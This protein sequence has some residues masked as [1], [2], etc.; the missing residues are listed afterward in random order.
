M[1]KYLPYGIIYLLLLPAL[2]SAQ[3]YSADVRFTIRNAGLTVDGSFGEVKPTI[4]FDE[5]MPEQA[6]IAA[7]V[8]V[9]S[10]NTGIQSRDRHLLKED[11]F[12]EKAFPQILIQSKKIRRLNGTQWEGT[13]NLTIKGIT[14]TITIPFQHEKTTTGAA[15]KARF[16]INRLNFKVGSSSWIMGD[17]VTIQVQLNSKLP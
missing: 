17:T 11:Y 8:I 2:L 3:S 9:S 10:I 14:Q 4:I 16:T 13:F 1:I 6:N 12:H 5:Q 15:L 7:T